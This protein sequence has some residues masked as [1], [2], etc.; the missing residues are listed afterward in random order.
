MSSAY[1]PGGRAGNRSC[2]FSFVVGV[3]SPPISAG[4]VTR[5]RAPRQDAALGVLD[6]ADERPGQ[7]LSGRRRPKNQP[8]A[9]SN[10]KPRRSRIANRRRFACPSSLPYGSLYQKREGAT[11][12]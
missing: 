9:T 1:D 11:K 12:C 10:N 2:P 6:A 7:P 3:T 4:E 5:T 8:A